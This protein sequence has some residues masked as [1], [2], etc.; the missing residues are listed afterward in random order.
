MLFQ[1]KALLL[2]QSLRVPEKALLKFIVRNSPPILQQVSQLS[3]LLKDTT[4]PFVLLEYIKWNKIHDDMVILSADFESDKFN[5][6]DPHPKT[7][8]HFLLSSF[9]N[10]RDH[11]LAEYHRKIDIA[12]KLPTTLKSSPELAKTATD[13]VFIGAKSAAAIGEP[14]D[15]ENI[16]GEV[17]V[18]ILEN[19]LHNNKPEICSPASNFLLLKGFKNRSRDPNTVGYFLK[20]HNTLCKNNSEDCEE[21]AFAMKDF[22]GDPSLLKLECK[23]SNATRMGF[24]KEL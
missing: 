22:L 3:N 4:T 7:P 14:F 18:S 19:C 13:T 5:K 21:V 16:L 23:R 9:L 11:E 10:A 8:A 24:C 15:A 17:G 6:D 2:T 20:F 12:K 1:E